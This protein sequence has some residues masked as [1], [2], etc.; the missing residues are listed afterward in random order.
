M[1]ELSKLLKAAQLDVTKTQGRA[2]SLLGKGFS[3]V[4]E[5]ERGAGEG[6]RNVLGR[7]HRVCGMR[8]ACLTHLIIKYF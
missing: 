2:S 6:G 7:G 5:R 4:S 8:E 3:S 1:R